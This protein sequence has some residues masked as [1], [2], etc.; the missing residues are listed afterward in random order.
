MLRRPIL[1][2]AL[3]A[4][5]AIALPASQSWAQAYPNRPIR[6]IVPL[7]PG[8]ANDVLGRL[9]AERMQA[10][11]GQ[12]V[13]V[14]N[15]PGVGGNIGTEWV[16]KQP[17]DGYTIL[18]SSNTHVINASFFARLP[19]DPIKDFE[20]ISLVATIP[21][22]LT[23]HA[24]MP[25]KDMR[26]FIAYLKANPGTTVG[27]SGIGTPHHL[28]SEL[29]KSMTGTNL[30]FVPYKGAAF[31]VPALLANEVTFSIAS[32]NTLVPHFKS[33]KLRP[34]AVAG[35]ERSSMLPDVPTIAE[36]G[37]LPGYAL[38]IWFGVL[39]PAGTPRPIIDRLNAE[40]NK[41]VRDPQIV[42]DRLN[43]IGLAPVGTTPEQYMNVMKADLVKY[44]K[45]AKDAGIKP[46]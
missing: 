13:V 21:F 41:V 19:Y 5:A 43:P 23:V 3:A 22:V 46:E 24:S 18:L 17:A 27:T 34:I 1:T 40:I 33:G 4:L 16:A 42:K 7:P 20:T 35:A 28:G 2:L 37:P 29:L 30:T 25:A 31:L 12:A 11:L 38:E 14:E 44:A 39:A 26:E 10:G 6:F 15:K 8:G 45:I 36:A 32:M 9:F